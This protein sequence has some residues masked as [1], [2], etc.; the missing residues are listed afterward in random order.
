MFRYLANINQGLYD[1][2]VHW[3]PQV[4]LCNPCAINYDY[5]VRFENLV[6]DSN[7]LLEYLQKNDPEK[8]KMFFKSTTSSRI[9]SS[10]TSKAFSSLDSDLIKR[11]A[12]VYKDDFR[13]MGYSSE[14]D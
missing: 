12:D 10:K 13:I 2:D 11:L 4:S 5:V 14:I 3:R 7:T 8:A 6:E 9:G 1:F